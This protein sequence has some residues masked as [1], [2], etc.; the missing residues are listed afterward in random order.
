MM[1]S[2]RALGARKPRHTEPIMKIIRENHAA[3][4]LRDDVRSAPGPLMLDAIACDLRARYEETASALPDRF[5]ALARR[6]D[7]ERPRDT[8]QAA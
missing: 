5:V 4:L 6:I 3:D 8:V 1:G 2:D 7:T